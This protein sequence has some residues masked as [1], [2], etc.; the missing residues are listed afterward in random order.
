MIILAEELFSSFL[1]SPTLFRY[2]FLKIQLHIFEA[3]IQMQK[4]AESSP[5]LSWSSAARDRPYNG[6]EGRGEQQVV[7]G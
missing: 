3:Q 4:D 5:L 1:L 6:V 2:I 7:G